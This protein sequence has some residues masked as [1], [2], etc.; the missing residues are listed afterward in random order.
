MQCDLYYIDLADVFTQ[1]DVQLRKRVSESL[2]L[3]KV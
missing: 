2:E 1:I 3:L